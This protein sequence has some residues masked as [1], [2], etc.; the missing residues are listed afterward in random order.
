MLGVD[1][2]RFWDS[3][4][5]ELEPY[6]K[7][8]EMMEERHDYHNWM[9]GQY[10]LSAVQ[11]AVSSVLAGKKS[12]AKYIDEPLLSKLKEEEEPNPEADFL[13]FSAWAVVFNENFKT[14]KGQ[15]E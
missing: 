15:G 13:K 9:L 6:R 1:E 8:D 5:K 11:T 2:Y 10:I 14:A 3:T 4:P 12:K 7:M